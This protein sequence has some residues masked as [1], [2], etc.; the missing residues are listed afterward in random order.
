MKNQSEEINGSNNLSNQLVE[1]YA[2]ESSDRFDSI[3]KLTIKICI[4]HAIR[5]SGYCK[6]PKLICNFKSILGM[7]NDDN[8]CYLCC[9]LPHKHKIDNHREKV[10]H[11]RKIYRK[12]SGSYT[13]SYRNKTHTIFELLNI[14]NMNFMK[15][16]S[17][18]KTLSPFYINKNLYEEQID[19]L[20]YEDQYCLITNSHSFV[21]IMKTNNLYVEDV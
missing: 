18:S 13:I 2:G 12:F 8:Y 4:H 19:L 9:K 6:L 21:R 5:A 7:E 16:L 3:T 14:I 20:L 17:S 1:V 10:S 11:L 15:L